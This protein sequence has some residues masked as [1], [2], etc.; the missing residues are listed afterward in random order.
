MEPERQHRQSPWP[1][2]LAVALALVTFPLIWVGGL[3]T[4]YDAGMAVPDWPGT[5]GYNLFLYPWQSWL[6]GAVGLVHRAWAPA[7][8]RGGR[9]ARHRPG[10]RRLAD[11]S[12][13]R[14]L[15]MA[16]LGALAL[17]ILQGVAGRCSRASRRAVGRR[18][19]TAASGRCFSLIW[20]AWSSSLPAGGWP[21]QLVSPLG[22][23]FA[24]AAWTTVALAYSQLILGAILRHIPLAALRRSVSGRPAVSFGAC[25]S[26]GRCMLLAVPW[27]VRQ[28]PTSAKGLTL[29]GWLLPLLVLGQ[30]A[31]GLGTYVAKYS[32]PAWLGDYPVCRGLRGAGTEPAAVAD[33]DG[34]R[35]QRLADPVRRGQPGH[36]EQPLFRVAGVSPAVI[37]MALVLGRRNACPTGSRRMS[38]TSISVAQPRVGSSLSRPRLRRADEAQNRRAGTGGRARRRRGGHLGPARS[39][40]RPARHAR[41]AAGGGQRQRRQPVAGGASAMP[42]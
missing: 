3:V 9:S 5:Y 40:G 34:P 8:G 19:S 20:P 1:H 23:R 13:A 24:R 17:V 26:A 22:A 10:R 12:A 38:I 32:L 39:G 37:G 42:A 30:I 2:R 31:L 41:H 15:R 11:R 35:R 14:W 28:L 25:R 18:W 27:R 7:A 21:P 16:R 4:T 29:F 6:A 36:A 33:H